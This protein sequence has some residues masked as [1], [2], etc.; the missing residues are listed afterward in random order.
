M[1]VILGNACSSV[2]SKWFS[3]PSAD[4]F[5]DLTRIGL[6]LEGSAFATSQTLENIAPG[7]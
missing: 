4:G 6:F 1:S 3:L 5:P 2:S 7:W